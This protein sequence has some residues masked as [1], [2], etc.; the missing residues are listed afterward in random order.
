M[1]RRHASGFRA[2]LMAV[3]AILALAVLFGLSA[4]RWGDDWAVWWRYITPVPEGLLVLYAAGWVVV[5]AGQGLY[6][7]RARWSIRREATDV[8]RA[9]AIMGVATLSV[10]FLFK[11]PD[12]SR[13]FLLVLFPVQ[14]AVTIATRV[15]IRLVMERLRREGRNLRYVLVLGAD[16]RAQE[17]AA[18]LESHPELGLRIAGFLSDK[19]F[20]AIRSP[21]KR[22]GMLN[23]LERILH[24]RIIDEV[25]ICL[26]FEQ[27]GLIDA[28]SRICEDEGKIVRIPMDV[29]G[30]AISVGR[31]EEL[32]GTPVF[33][34]V[35][36]PDR[37]MAL[38]T[39]RLVD[40]VASVL[41][42]AV[43]SPVLAVIAIAIK[44]DGGGPVFFHQRRVGLN[45]RPFEVWKFRS[46]TIDAEA[47]LPAI[48]Y[49]N[50]I[51]GHAFK[52]SNDPRVTR[53]GRF[54][55]RTS[56]DELPQLWNVLV[57]QMSLVGPRPP[58]PAEVRDYDLWH[59]RRLSMKPGITGLW[60]VRA[61]RAPRFDQWVAA[62]LEY[63]DRWSLWLDLKILFRTIPAALEGR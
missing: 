2:L 40:V 53:V 29:L 13:L 17:F 36:G 20:Q 57:G 23:E 24:S 59:R 45:G 51:V 4:W 47:R 43:L 12:V 42:L 39:K 33:S 7:P 49:G 50:E 11:L 3:D 37:G 21:W 34:L 48:R 10:L 41:G 44:L 22:L 56:L 19:P 61:R 32:D 63:I 38:A 58:L 25:A 55:R 15:V 52:L 6:R 27:W 8:I 28:I 14:A 31:V 5:V 62:D 1:I 30:R 16:E 35:S 46:M 18:T 26:P 54:L 9:A 60:Q